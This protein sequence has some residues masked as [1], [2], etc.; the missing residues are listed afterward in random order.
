MSGGIQNLRGGHLNARTAAEASKG[1]L[2]ALTLELIE[3]FLTRC[4]RSLPS[5]QPNFVDGGRS[6]HN[7][8]LKRTLYNR[9][10]CLE[11]DGAHPPR[12]RVRMQGGDA[13]D[14]EADGE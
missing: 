12:E 7:T 14:G 5:K 4:L 8:K 9:H 11:L 13:P 1:R 10:F 6:G 2:R 3:M